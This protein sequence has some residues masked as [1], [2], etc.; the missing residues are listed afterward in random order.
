VRI[1][2]KADYAMRAVLELAAAEDPPVKR[3]EIVQA[4][5]IP[6]K[7]LE[8]ILGE[9]KHGGIVSSQRGTEGGYWLARPAKEI[10]VADVMRVVEGPL[11]S[12]RE[13]RPEDIEY[14]G[15][16]ESLREVWVALRANMREVLEGVTLAD[17]A[18][19]KL[20]K[21]V[22]KITELPEAWVSH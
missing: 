16:A 13:S 5:K 3:A 17:I 7:F 1:S 14:V 15:A 11:A 10:T 4:Q 6:V 12:I 9:L 20:P 2:A 21:P 22:E 18:H 8:S 19:A